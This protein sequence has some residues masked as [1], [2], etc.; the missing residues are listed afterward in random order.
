M[1]GDPHFRDLIEAELRIF[2]ARR[3][4]I[5]TSPHETVRAVA[6]AL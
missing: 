4:V 1:P 5:L 3:M 2:D 6:E